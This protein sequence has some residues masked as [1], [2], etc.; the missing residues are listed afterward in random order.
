MVAVRDF[1]GL[2]ISAWALASAAASAPTLVLECC[3]TDL[4][5]KQF[6]ADRPGFRSL[7]P[8]SV[9]RGLFGVLRQKRLQL[10]LGPVVVK[11]GRPGLAIDVGKLRP[12]VGAAHVDSP[13]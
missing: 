4:L 13:D 7:R 1:S 9:P 10:R 12:G 3:M 2:A 8:Q 11:R 5:G 6:K